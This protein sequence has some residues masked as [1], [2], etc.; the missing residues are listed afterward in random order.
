MFSGFYGLILSYKLFR[1]WVENFLVAKCNFILGME[2]LQDGTIGLV[3]R[4]YE[5]VARERH[6]VPLLLI[7]S[8]QVIS[9]DDLK[10]IQ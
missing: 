10:E 4:L 6:K 1:I 8:I 5:R 3:D 2:M 9:T 7:L